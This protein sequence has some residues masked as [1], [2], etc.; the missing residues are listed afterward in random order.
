MKKILKYTFLFAFVAL[1]VFY[2]IVC[3]TIF[4]AVKST[5]D[6]A[7]Q[8]YQHRRNVPQDKGVVQRLIDRLR[9][10]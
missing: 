8:Q 10:L 9:G 2:G 5:T 3:W 4:A 1:F 6:L 7:Q